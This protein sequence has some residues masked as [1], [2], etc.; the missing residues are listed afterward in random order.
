MN[1]KPWCTDC[2]KQNTGAFY[3]HMWN[4]A[5][6]VCIDEAVK[7]ENAVVQQLHAPTLVFSK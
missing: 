5:D 2:F 4:S 3:S 7:R 1:Y 6:H